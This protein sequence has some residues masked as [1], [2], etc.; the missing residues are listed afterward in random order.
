MGGDWLEWWAEATA[1]YHEPKVHDH[2][3]YFYLA[4]INVYILLPLAL[5]GLFFNATALVS[6]LNLIFKKIN[7][8]EKKILYYVLIKK[9]LNLYAKYKLKFH[10]ILKVCIDCFKI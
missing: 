8:L 3:L 10:F 2:E 4:N 1:C 7:N 5:L 6:F 9:F